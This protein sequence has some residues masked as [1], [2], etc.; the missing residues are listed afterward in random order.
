MLYYCT[1]QGEE[2]KKGPQLEVETAVS[3]IS[4][5]NAFI[6]QLTTQETAKASSSR[7]SGMR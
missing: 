5:H 1:G 7:G 4:A 2:A 3:T 6:G